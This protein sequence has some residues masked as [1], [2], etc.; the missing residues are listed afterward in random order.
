[1]VPAWSQ[2]PN[3]SPCP[4][5]YRCNEVLIP[6]TRSTRVSSTVVFF[7]PPNYTLSSISMA[8]EDTQQAAREV[9]QTLR[10]MATSNPSNQV[11]GK[12]A[13]PKQLSDIIEAG[14]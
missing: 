2:G 7:P 10:D 8:E 6:A 9:G 1:M 13:G 3:I 4:K 5:H 14:A 11:L 12:H